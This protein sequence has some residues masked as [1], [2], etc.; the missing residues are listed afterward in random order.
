MITAPSNSTVDIGK[1]STFH[2]DEAAIPAGPQGEASMFWMWDQRQ[3]G[4][5]KFRRWA[6]SGSL[7][8]S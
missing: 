3:S 7:T 1:R 5:S 2:V 4:T 8:C 6:P